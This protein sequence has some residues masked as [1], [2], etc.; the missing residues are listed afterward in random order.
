MATIRKKGK[1]WQVQIRR[2]GFPPLSK[3]FSQRDWARRWAQETERNLEMGSVPSSVH[4]LRRF[5]LGPLLARYR[6]EVTPTKKGSSSETYRLN[7]MIGAPIASVSLDNLTVERL[8]GYR[9]KRLKEVRP[10]SVRREL[11]ILQHCLDVAQNEWGVPLTSNP[12][13]SLRLPTAGPSRT[14]RPTEMELQ[15]LVSAARSRSWYLAPIIELAV[16]TGMRRSELLQLSWAD[17]DVNAATARIEKSKNGLARTVLLSP[18]A[19]SV[20]SALPRKDSR[21]FDVSPNAVRLSWERLTAAVGASDLHFHDLRHEA[22]SR[23]F[24]LGLT[25]PEVALMSG[26][27]D[28]RTLMRYAHPQHQRILERLNTSKR[29]LFDQVLEDSAESGGGS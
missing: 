10:A 26:H 21:V 23:W 1:G 24:E 17:V 7:R 28:T 16:E 11:A 20:F 5:T 29:R 4:D 9:D 13:K 2:K 15:S 27:R 18:G 25:H 22:V 8:A 12:M 6:D 3:S 19:L 14:R